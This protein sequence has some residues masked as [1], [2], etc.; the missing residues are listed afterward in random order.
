MSNACQQD[1]LTPH[2]L[3]LGGIILLPR[4]KHAIGVWGKNRVTQK[5]LVH[6]S[7]LTK[8]KGAHCVIA[9]QN[10]VTDTMKVAPNTVE[11]TLCFQ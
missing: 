10:P 5:S 4:A 11:V 6:R 7:P 1:G 3:R 8:A 2:H 9:Q